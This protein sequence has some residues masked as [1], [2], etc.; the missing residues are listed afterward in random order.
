MSAR[1][2]CDVALMLFHCEH[3][4]D[5]ND[6]VNDAAHSLKAVGC[7]LS[8]RLRDLDMPARDIHFHEWPP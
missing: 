2:F 5:F 3:A 8:K 6:V 4:V 1:R 7:E